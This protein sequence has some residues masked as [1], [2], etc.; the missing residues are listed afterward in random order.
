MNSGLVDDLASVVRSQVEAWMAELELLRQDPR[1]RKF[2]ELRQKID[3][4]DAFVIEADAPPLSS[5]SPRFYPYEEYDAFEFARD[6]AGREV[7]TL[8][9][10]VL[11]SGRFPELSHTSRRHMLR[12]L[13][14][15]G[16]AEIARHTVSGR[17][18]LYRFGSFG[19]GGIGA[20][21]GRRKRLGVPD[22][23]LSGFKADDLNDLAVRARPSRAG[24]RLP[25]RLE[26][27]SAAGAVAPGP[28]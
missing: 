26:T 27:G 23:E 4:A 17:P 13:I 1:V 5:R 18:R 15:N 19:N 14:E 10:S 21:G 3:E 9:L 28:P 8:E 16:A 22:S 6:L 24:V 25:A 7:S 20:I 11:A 12:Y 2:A